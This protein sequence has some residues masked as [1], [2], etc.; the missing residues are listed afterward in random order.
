M[1]STKLSCLFACI[2]KTGEKFSVRTKLEYAIIESAQREDIS[3][4]INRH[5]GVELRITAGRTDGRA[6]SPHR[7]S[8]GV[9][10]ND[11]IAIPLEGGDQP[12]RSEEHTS[13]LQSLA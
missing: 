4:S 3:Q 11:V 13:E 6:D 10:T 7:L 2:S 12:A 1:R 5:L 8:G 9:E